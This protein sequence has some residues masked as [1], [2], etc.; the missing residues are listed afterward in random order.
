VR[1]NADC[2]LKVFL[3]Y[4]DRHAILTK[5]DDVRGDAREARRADGLSIAALVS[6]NLSRNSNA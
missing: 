2:R 6:A 1:L 5:V 3:I 4:G